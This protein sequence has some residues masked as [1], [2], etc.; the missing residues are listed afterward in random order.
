MRGSFVVV[1]AATAGLVGVAAGQLEQPD[2][3]Q[4]PE[5]T[6]DLAVIGSST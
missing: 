3:H 1:I 4:R 6:V 2:A 5:A